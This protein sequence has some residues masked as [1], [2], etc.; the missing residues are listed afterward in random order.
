MSVSSILGLL[1][2][3]EGEIEP[4]WKQRTYLSHTLKNNISY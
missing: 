1:T 3:V 2:I 4:K